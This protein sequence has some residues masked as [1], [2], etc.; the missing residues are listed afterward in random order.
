MCNVLTIKNLHVEN[1]G[2]PPDLKR[3][4][5]GN[6][7][8]YFENR[9]GEQLIFTYDRNQHT[10]ILYHGDCCW[11]E[12]VPV[13]AGD[14]PGVI[15]DNDESQWLRLTW[16]VASLYEPDE[17]KLASALMSMNIHIAN[18]DLLIQDVSPEHQKVLLETRM[19]LVKEQ[20]LLQQSI[21]R[22]QKLEV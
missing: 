4:S 5:G 12:P 18:I 6:Y 17:I 13:Y 9:H 15:L 11:D 21:E 1:C 19:K 7:T 3:E 2:T 14:A 22:L 16:E 10:G 8:S 20:K